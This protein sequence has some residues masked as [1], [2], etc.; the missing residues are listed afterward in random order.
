M[1]RLLCIENV[2]IYQNGAG[3]WAEGNISVRGN[4]ISAVGKQRSE[5]DRRPNEVIDAGGAFAIPGF[6]DAHCHLMYD[7]VAD[8]V[9]IELTKPI[10]AAAVGA[11]VNAGTVLDA[12]FTTVRDVGSRGGI[13]VAVRDEVRR[14]RIRGPRIFA[15]GRI[16][17]TPG[18]MA[19]LQPSHVF[20]R[21]PYPYGLGE[22]IVGP[23]EARAA[24]RRQ[25]KDGVDWIKVAVS[26]TGFN[27]LCPA[28]RAGMSA[29]EL[30]AIVGEAKIQGVPVAAHAESAWA[31]RVAANAGVTTIE[32]ALEL[33]DAVV[34]T[35][36]NEGIAVCPTLAMYTAFV[37]RGLEHGIP[38]EIV[39]LHRRS[40]DRHVASIRKAYEAGVRIITG[41]DAGLSHFPQGS[42]LQ[43]AVR[44]VELIGM[45]SD[46]AIAA[47]TKNV[48]E[49]LG[50]QEELGSLEVDK[51]ADIVLLRKDPIADI[52]TLEET[53]NVRLVVQEGRVVTL[54][55]ATSDCG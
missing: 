46:E 10:S 30:H 34:E 27:P 8:P 18:G 25:I 24:V 4:K 15:A 37:E 19:D 5:I 49:V 31:V 28:E 42:C 23:Y 2:M 12:G 20:E 9:S 44:L 50:L 41:G 43:E 22:I 3:G 35:L 51:I 47:M 32:H 33:D 40:H 13:G 17:T 26:G 38:P 53:G 6:C 14:G 48:A 55:R 1:E 11:V 16:L 7:G 21:M 52:K 54:P 36:L 45:R 29:E 39:D